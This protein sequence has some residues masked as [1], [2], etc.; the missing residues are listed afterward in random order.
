MP[1]ERRSLAPCHKP[2]LRCPE[3]L[4]T[5]SLQRSGESQKTW[6]RLSEAKPR[7]VNS[8]FKPPKSKGA[9]TTHPRPLSPARGEGCHV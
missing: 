8:W 9:F 7:R 2:E 6:L 3:T 4:V 1:P 5:S